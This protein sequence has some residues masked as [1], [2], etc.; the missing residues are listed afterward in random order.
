ML[1]FQEGRDV[2]HLGT[3]PLPSLQ[4]VYIRDMEV[5]GSWAV[6]GC[7]S[8]ADKATEHTHYSCHSSTSSIQHYNPLVE[9]W[10]SQHAG[11]SGAR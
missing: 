5:A 4:A 8:A 10:S 1:G 11:A 3:D 2:G 7:I 6:A 9:S